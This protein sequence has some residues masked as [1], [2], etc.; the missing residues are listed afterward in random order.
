MGGRQSQE[1]SPAV[2]SQTPPSTHHHTTPPLHHHTAPP[3]QHGTS[4]HQSHPVLSE[5]RHLHPTSS[6]SQRHQEQQLPSLSRSLTLCVS[7]DIVAC[8]DI[9]YRSASHT[10]AAAEQLMELNIALATLQQRLRAREE[11][12]ARP[13]SASHHASLPTGLPLLFFRQIASQPLGAP[14]ITSRSIF[15]PIA[16]QCPLC[17]KDVPSTEMEA[18]TVQCMSRPRVTYNG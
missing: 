15:F 13:H 18:H 3:S 16:L 2:A 4:H 5:Y 8:V 10:P 6:A 11:A 1:A 17:S 14:E 7:S 9:S 12:R